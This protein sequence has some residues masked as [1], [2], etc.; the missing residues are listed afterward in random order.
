MSLASFLLDHKFVILFYLI[1]A[2]I[3]TFNWKKFEVQ[4]K[5]ILMYKTRIGIKWM[6]RFGKKHHEFLKILGYTGMGLGF[7]GMVGITYLIFDGLYN[8]IFVPAAP[9]TFSLVIP[10]VQIPGVAIFV[11]F[12]YGIISLFFVV[13]IHESGHGLI[14]SAYNLRIKSTGIFF[15]GPLIGAFVE[16][17]EQ[18]FKKVDEVTQ[19]SVF[20]AGPFANIVLAIIAGLVLFLA[21]SPIQNAMVE[22][23]GF[24]FEEI[25]AGFPAEAAGVQPGVTYT[26]VDN[27]TVLTAQGLADALS[28]TGPNENVTIGNENTT[29]TILTTSNPSAPDQG[30][31]GV[32]GIIP[33]YQLKNPSGFNKGIFFILNI[34]NELLKW[35]IILSVGI[36]LANLLPLGPTDGGQMF[37]T[38][39]VKIHGKEKGLR[40]WGRTSIILLVIIL[41]LIIT[42]LLQALV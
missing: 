25:Q 22:Q 32:M 34:L 29:Y 35:I 17:D 38:V 33:E 6:E 36:G 8:L 9:A 24:S 5:F 3:I 19:Y 42:P 26:L 2:L 15:L 12:W 27:K 4:A 11:P 23:T 7:A 40:I 16:N 31:I 39:M 28:C 20:G 21:V 18:E 14:A 10:G 37:R 41:I 30:Y 13:L 1:I